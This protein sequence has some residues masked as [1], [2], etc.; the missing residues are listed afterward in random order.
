VSDGQEATNPPDKESRVRR[1]KEGKAEQTLSVCVWASAKHSK[2][3][4]LFPDEQLEAFEDSVTDPDNIQVREER[5]DGE[6][7]EILSVWVLPNFLSNRKGHGS[8]KYLCTQVR[9]M[10]CVDVRTA[11]GCETPE[12]KDAVVELLKRL[13]WELPA[14]K[15]RVM[16]PH[17]L[18]VANTSDKVVW[19]ARRSC[20]PGM[21]VPKDLFEAIEPEVMLITEEDAGKGGAQT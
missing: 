21:G 19:G 4:I 12:A 7:L 20:K 18:S 14:I 17:A 5:V 11:D 16:T 3:I 15:P 9:F 8:R 2:P 6:R 10:V 13:W 1:L